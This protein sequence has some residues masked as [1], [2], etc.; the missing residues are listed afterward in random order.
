VDGDLRAAQL[1]LQQLVIAD[2]SNADYW[3][4][5]GKVSMQLGQF[6]A[7]YEAYLRAHELDRANVEPLAVL[8][9]LA[10]RS[11]NLEVAQQHAEQLEIVAP[12]NPAVSL[13][14]G[15]VALRRGDYEEASRQVVAFGEVAPYDSSGKVLQSLIFMAQGQPDQAIALLQDQIKQQ[16][17]DAASLRAIAGI[18]ELRERWREA[19]D[20]LRNYLSWQPTDQQARIRLIEAALRSQQVEPAAAVTLK[21]VQKE[22][23]DDLLAPWVALGK[24]EVIA[25]RLFEWA[26]MADVGRRIAVARFLATTSRPEQ[27]IALTESSAILPVRPNNTIA[28]ALF[29]EALA[30]TGR[31]KEGMARLD[32]VLEIDGANRE[33]LRGRALLRSKAGSHKGAIEDAQKLVSVDDK[34]APVRLLV[35][36]IYAASGDHD[37]ARRT[38]WEAFHDIGED[39]TIFDA[40]RPLVMKS[41]GAQAAARLS[42]EY[43]DK[44]NEKLTRS[45]T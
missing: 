32:E 34:S 39:R 15:Y 11:G 5:L 40:L 37:G 17:S 2:D 9:Q 30:R 4:E 14:K 7:G 3:A 33:A 45:I 44:R 42:Q 31:S 19:A 22:D 26:K 29:G 23:I 8:T 6:S 28:N 41:D 16:P 43:Y 38:L 25:D 13:T 20:A 1:A 24:Q 21:A 18:F 35:A 12:T 27:V 36:R 10:L